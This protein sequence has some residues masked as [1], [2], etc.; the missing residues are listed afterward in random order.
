MKDNTNTNIETKNTGKDTAG[1]FSNRL[2]TARRQL[3]LSQKE[4]AA[5]LEIAPSYLSE[6]ESGKTRPGFEFFYKISKLFKI[7]P[8]Y[9][10][11]GE[12]LIFIETGKNWY[13]DIDFGSLNNEVQELIWHMQQSPTMTHAILEFFPRYL[14]NNRELIEAEIKKTKEK[15]K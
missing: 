9:L 2:R 15:N 6:I 8:I 13:Q 10:L 3:H 7:S 4:F 1:D 12:G 11:H 5:R 14:Y